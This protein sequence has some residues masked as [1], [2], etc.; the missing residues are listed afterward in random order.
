MQSLAGASG[1]A[2]DFIP[3]QAGRDK[4]Q[5]TIARADEQNHL[6]AKIKKSAREEYRVTIREF[7]NYRG[8]DLRLYR[9]NGK[10][11]FVETTRAIAIRPESLS[12]IADALHLAATMVGDAS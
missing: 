6:I 8:V 10:G 12:F 7:T 1:E 11:D 2:C 4:S 3:H 5:N 9:V